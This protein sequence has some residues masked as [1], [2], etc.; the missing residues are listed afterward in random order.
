M[1]KKGET[2]ELTELEIPNIGIITRGIIVEHPMFGTG[3]VEAIFEFIKSGE[4]TIRINFDKHGSKA[5]VPEY[6][7]LILPKPVSKSNSLLGKLFGK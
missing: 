5:L 3:E 1:P 6:A 4:N 2:K 7:N